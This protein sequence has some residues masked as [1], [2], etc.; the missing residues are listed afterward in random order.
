MPNYKYR[1]KKGPQEVIEGTIE[2]HSQDEAI[3]KLSQQG[4][5]PL[6]IEQQ[7]EKPVQT[8]KIVTKKG[9]GR[10]RSREIT[11][12]TRQLA[13]LLKSGVSILDALSIIAEQSESTH[14]RNLIYYIHDEVRQGA[15]LSAPLS[16]FPKIFSPLYIAMIRTGE[17]GGAL[18]QSLLRIAEYR[19]K[20]EQMLSRF[21][22]AMAYPILM[23][24]VGFGTIVFMFVFVLPRLTQI[25]LDMKQQ[26]PLPTKILLFIT[27][28]MKQW[29]GWCA[30]AGAIII[31]LFSRQAKTEAMRIRISA[32]KLTLPIFRDFVLK[33]ELARFSLTLELLI[34]SGIPILRAIEIAI[35]VLDNE[36][37]KKH[38]RDSYAALERGGSFGRSLKESKFIPLFMS[39]LIIVGEESGRLAES[40]GEIGDSYERDTDDALKVF[41]TLLEPLMILV[42]GLIVGFIV[43]AMLLPIFEINII[44][45]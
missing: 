1:A 24:A 8:K 6:N 5:L 20:E 31:L 18:P 2:A 40:L 39:N 9:I 14:L 38:L 45:S 3:E 13:S 33:A 15:T 19:A 10:V 21:R 29:G 27:R 17:D 16:V 41:A 35:P 7:E 37:I 22:M 30:I 25:Y 36:V 32:F 34:R 42:M 28:M 12:M 44:A 26:L 4:Y 11:L 43:M 23:T